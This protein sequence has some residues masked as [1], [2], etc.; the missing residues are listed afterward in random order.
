[1]TGRQMYKRVQT[2]ASDV[3]EVAAEDYWQ[4]LADWPAILDWMR[5]ER[6]PVPLIRVEL[7]PGHEVGRVPCT[8]SC[9]FDTSQLPSGVAVPECVPETLLH[10]DPTARFLYYN[11]EGDGPFGMRN[12][13]A[14]TE[15][16]DLGDGRTRVTC[17]GRFDLPVDALETMVKPFIEGIY[18]SIIH[19]IAA[20]VAA[21]A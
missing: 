5:E 15:V 3:V 10:C 13:L 16:D 12:Y 21:R 1:M 11:M 19:D 7:E 2:Y 18:D 17:R 6:K 4:L 14:M 20:T 8:R 9:Y